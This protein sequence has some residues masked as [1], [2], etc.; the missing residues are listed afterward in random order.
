MPTATLRSDN[1]FEAARL[2]LID[3]LAALQAPRGL[4]TFPLP[5]DFRHLADH[6]REAAGLFDEWLAVIGHQVNVSAPGGVDMRVFED[7]FS[8][9]VEGNA[10]FVVE[11]VA[12]DMIENRRAA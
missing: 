10:T 2:A 8:A 6:I 4:A 9:A 5:A 3:R 1:P 7:A 11:Q 12:E